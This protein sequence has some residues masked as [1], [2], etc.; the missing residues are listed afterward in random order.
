MNQSDLFHESEGANQPPSIEPYIGEVAIHFNPTKESIQDAIDYLKTALDNGELNPL[1]LAIRMKWMEDYMK[2][3]KEAIRPHVL[4]SVNKYTKGEEIACYG[5]RIEPM[6]AGT[7]YDY[8]GCG[9]V[10]WN[11]LQKAKEAHDKLI[12]EREKFL[13]S[14]KGQQ[15]L[16]DDSTGEVYTVFP[17]KKTSTSTYKVTLKR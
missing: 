14:I 12:K 1:E 3:A 7:R 4:T 2:E 9:D 10:V 17:P 16:V 8:S 11:E 6:E 5:S 15:T 13:Q